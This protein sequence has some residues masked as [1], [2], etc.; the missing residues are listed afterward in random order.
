MYEPRIVVFHV[1][2]GMS[3]L[4]DNDDTQMIIADGDGRYWKISNAREK[5]LFAES[6]ADLARIV[7]AGGYTPADSPTDEPL[8]DEPL[9]VEPPP[10]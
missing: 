8:T 4:L 7:R 3:V 10:G 2:R 9:T 5:T 6:A 1:G